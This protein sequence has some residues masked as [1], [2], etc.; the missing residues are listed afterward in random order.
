[1]EI[2]DANH[3]DDILDSPY[4]Y[5]RQFHEER[6][7]HN[8]ISYLEAYRNFVFDLSLSDKILLDINEF[9]LSMMQKYLELLKYDR[10]KGYNKHRGLF[11][12]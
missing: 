5:E 3:Y 8:H 6:I 10:N 11:F 4:Y 7:I 1:M 2:K 12:P 9:L